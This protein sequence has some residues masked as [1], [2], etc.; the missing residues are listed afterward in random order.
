LVCGLAVLL[1]T[2]RLT[3]PNHIA[4][5]SH[6]PGTGRVALQSGLLGVVAGTG[7]WSSPQVLHYLAPAA[8]WLCW[9]FRRDLRRLATQVVPP[10]LRPILLTIALYP[11]I[12]AALPTTYYYGEPRY[13][14]FL[15]PLLAL[16]AG[17]AIAAI[18]NLALR[19]VAVAG[20]LAVT[21]N[22]LSHMVELQGPPG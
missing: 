14:D 15:W 20:V 8:L 21:A 10:A 17:W 1:L 11:L 3:A 19:A 12:F 5:E 7:W 22:G 13:L 2:L 9:S 4:L 16:L 18:P 6:A